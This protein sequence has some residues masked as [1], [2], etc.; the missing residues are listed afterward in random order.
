MGDK[1]FGPGR[2]K[3]WLCLPFSG[4]RVIRDLVN[5][6][7]LGYHVYMD[8]YYSDPHLFLELLN[9]EIYACGTIRSNRIG[10]PKDL[11]LSK[12]EESTFE[13]GYYRWR[14]NKGLVAAVWLDKRPVYIISTAHPPYGDNNPGKLQEVIRHKPD[15][16]EMHIHCPPAE[17]YYQQHM[18]GVDRG[19]QVMKTL[20]VARKSRKAWKKLFSY[21]LEISLM[22]AFIVEECFKPHS[23]PGH[24]D[25]TFLKFC[26]ELANELIANQSFRKKAGRRPSLPMSE[27]DTKCLHGSYHQISYQEER[28]DCVVYA[29]KVKHFRLDKGK[30]YRSHIACVACGHK[31]FCLNAT[32]N[33]WEKWHNQRQYWL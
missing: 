24:R 14:A 31:Y 28:M 16:T 7:G 9:K 12:R 29:A 10:F 11:V 13:R 23:Q 21:G 22:N 6:D 30:R 1:T 26:L 27:I 8:N 4:R 17:F 33:C 18:I 5:F 32:R 15:R 20:N 19:D 25:R 3:D 2:V